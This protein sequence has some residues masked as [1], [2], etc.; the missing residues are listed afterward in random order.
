M[1]HRTQPQTHS[2]N[3]SPFTHAVY[4]WCQKH[5]VTDGAYG[6][7]VSGGKDSVLLWHVLTEL[8]SALNL[9]LQLLHVHH[10]PDPEASIQKHRDRARRHC[11]DLAEK[12][13]AR[14]H[15]AEA[16]NKLTGEAQFR[17]FRQ[18]ALQ[19]WE[20]EL[21]LKAIFLAHHAQDLLETR[22]L[23]LIRGTG[24]Q[25]L[26]AMNEN[27]AARLRPFLRIS[28]SEIEAE[29]RRRD[30]IWE[31]DPSNDSAD[32]LRNWLRHEWLV[33]LET[34]KPGAMQNLGQSLEVMAQELES[35]QENFPPAG[36]F[37][38]SR[39]LSHPVYLQLSEADQRRTLA[40]FLHALKGRD[41][42][43]AQINEIR[44]HLDKPKNEHKFKVTGL[45][46][47][48][49]PLYIEAFSD[50]FAAF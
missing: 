33:Q 10:G 16:P 17:E 47:R 7:A 27:A 5:R 50:S 8:R 48:V 22:L 15:S 24:G 29:L 35:A 34:R 6:V 31:Q 18:H 20:A 30:L 42:S 36:L 12:S 25:G 41:Y 44:K 14:F 28:G 19:G 11:A 13:Q 26:A 43:L 32:Y 23:R 45:W 21:G 46:W 2:R 49:T 9:D 4:R 38:G 39:R 37:V 1:S 3:W 40:R